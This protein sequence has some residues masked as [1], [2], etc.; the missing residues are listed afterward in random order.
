MLGIDFAFLNEAQT[1]S[2]LFRRADL[3][4]AGGPK[5]AGL[6]PTSDDALNERQIANRPRNHCGVWAV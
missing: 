5:L 1:V 3:L 2:G 4:H 6:S